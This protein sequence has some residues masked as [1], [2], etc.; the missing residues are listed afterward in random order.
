MSRY[1]IEFL[2]T[3]TIH[4]AYR[5]NIIAGRVRDRNVISIIGGGSL[6]PIKITPEIL[7]A[8][9]I[10]RDMMYR[11]Y[12]EEAHNFKY[13]G[14]KGVTV[15][16]T[17]KVFSNFYEELPKVEGF[18]K[19]LIIE[20]KIT[21]DKDS[22]Q[23]GVK[24][25]VYSLATCR[26]LTVKEQ[27]NYR[28]NHEIPIVGTNKDGTIEWARSAAEF[29]RKHNLDRSSITKVLKGKLHQSKGWKFVYSDEVSNDYPE[30]E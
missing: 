2:E 11:C 4:E 6:G 1:T 20:D 3:G 21:L 19:R 22:K 24:Y 29:A 30:G 15:C 9:Y 12:K 10:W 18:D 16:D 5:H 14:G 23:I 7:W 26:F 25:K 27:G 28:E 8:Y 13:Y 17:W